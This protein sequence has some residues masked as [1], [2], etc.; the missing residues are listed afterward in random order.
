MNVTVYNQLQFRGIIE[1][2]PKFHF[3]ISNK[4]EIQSIGTEIK[5][6]QIWGTI[7]Y[8]TGGG[9][10]KERLDEKPSIG[11]YAPIFDRHAPRVEEDKMAEHHLRRRLNIFGHLSAQNAPPQRSVGMEHSR[12]VLMTRLQRSGGKIIKNRSITHIALDPI[13]ITKKPEVKRR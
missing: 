9:E 7:W 1:I 12:G 2:N 5:L 4:N 13:N 8:C 10:R 6:M 3:K 11:A